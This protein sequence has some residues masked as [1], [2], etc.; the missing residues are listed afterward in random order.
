MEQVTQPKK[1]GRK[2]GSKNKSKR[3][4]LKG[5]GNSNSIFSELEKEIAGMLKHIQRAKDLAAKELEKLEQRHARDLEKQRLKLEM[6]VSLWKSRSK[7][8]RKKLTSSGTNRG[9]VGRPPSKSGA[10][11]GRPVGSISRKGGGRKK[12]GELTK[13]DIILNFIK[14][15]QKPVSSREL[16]NLLFERSG[17]TEKKRYEQGIYTTLTLMY[18]NK[19]LKKT[20]DNLIVLP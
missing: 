18:R 2:P 3:I 16:I 19:L 1:R 5:A 10:K 15:Y 13:K 7:D 11:R 8:Y 6:S 17:E 20:K 4:T 14:E 9:K 12:A